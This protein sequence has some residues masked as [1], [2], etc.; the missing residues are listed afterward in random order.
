M[1][2]GAAGA[3]FA[4]EAVF[5]SSKAEVSAFFAPMAAGEQENKKNRI[6]RHD[7]DGNKRLMTDG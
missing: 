2:A 4:D 3:S 5:S 7:R 1:S 6:T